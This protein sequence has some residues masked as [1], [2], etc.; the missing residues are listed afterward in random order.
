MPVL[1][2]AIIPS[3][4]KRSPSSALVG[5]DRGRSADR[6]ARLPHR[7]SRSSPSAAGA[8]ASAGHVHASARRSV[9]AAAAAVHSRR[10]PPI[11]RELIDQYC[12]TCHNDRLHT[13][14]LALE[15]ARPSTRS[16]PNADVWEKVCASCERPDAAGRPPA[17][18]RGRGRRL[19]LL[20]RRP[21]RRARRGAPNPGRPVTHRLNRTE[22]A[23]A[24]AICWRSR[25]TRGRCCPP[26]TPTST[27]STTTPTCC[28]C[29]PRCSSAICR[30][31]ARSA[32]WRSAVPAD[33][34]ASTPTRLSDEL[35]QDERA[36]DE[37]PFG[38]R[39]GA[40][41]D[42]LLPGRRRVRRQGPAAEDALQH[43]R[44]LAEPHELEVRLDR[45]RVKRFTLGGIDSRRR[46]RRALPARCT[47][48]PEWEALRATTR[49]TRLEVRFAAKA[50]THVVGVSFSQQGLGARRR[51]AAAAQGGWP[52]RNRRDV[53]RQ[54]GRRERHHRRSVR[55]RRRRRHAE[56]APHLHLP[57]QGRRRGQQRRAPARG[58]ILSPLAR[59]AYRRP[60]ADRRPRD[61]AGRSI[62]AGRPRRRLRGRHRDSRSSACSSA[63]T[64]CS[65][66]K[67]ARAASRRERRIA[68]AISSWRRGCRSSSGAA[69]PTTNCSTSPR[70]DVCAI[71]RCSSGRCGG[72][73]PTRASTALVDNFAGQWLQ[74]REHARRRCPIPI[75]SPT[76][77][78][79]CAR[80][81]SRR[82]SCFSRAR[83]ARIAASPSC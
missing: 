26:T 12:V 17:A 51:P 73:W 35:M 57:A 39:G 55:D 78:R 70:A 41:I 36:S 69:S 15:Q 72:C 34:R 9:A 60:V 32:G 54:P 21:A 25:S 81:S 79:T 46:R 3:R 62:D 23:N 64:S 44:G 76:S 45:E 82:P 63:P 40:A 10:S 1:T 74:L 4:R 58:R 14:G 65:A 18:R 53:R 48:N 71:R 29:R 28:R 49:T 68:S 59:R 13:A 42:A 61:A 52:L 33:G 80:R 38:S 24:I 6:A 22:Y 5:I 50:G 20:A 2:V 27:G 66:S 31:R 19:H 56:P 37:L 43:V 47:W 8:A 67:R 30:R 83:C 75:C 11:T 77:T 16:A 7:A